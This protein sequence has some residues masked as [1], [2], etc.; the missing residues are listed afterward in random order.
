MKMIDILMDHD[1]QHLSGGGGGTPGH[2]VVGVPKTA[3]CACK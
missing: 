3:L 1:R 2:L